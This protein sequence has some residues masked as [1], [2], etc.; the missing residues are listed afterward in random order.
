MRNTLEFTKC[1]LCYDAPCAKA[2]PS[3]RIDRFMRSVKMENYAGAAR[4]LP[5]TGNP[6]IDCQAPCCQVCPMKMDIPSLISYAYQSVHLVDISNRTNEV[7]L[8]C[9]LCGIPLENPFLLSSSVVASNYDMCARAFR[10]GWAGAAFK[11][12]SLM[13]MH[14][15]SP[16]FS[17]LRGDGV[18]F[19]GFKNIEQLS[20]HSLEENLTCFMELKRDF[21]TKVIIASIMGRNEEEWT[22]LAKAVTNAGADVVELNFSCP[23]MEDQDAGIT[24]GQDPDLV[25]R[26]TQA[27]CKGTD[28]PVLAKMTP[29]L[30]DMRLPARAAMEGGASGI[31]AINTIKSI[32]DVNLDTLIAQPEVHGKSSVGGYS[33]RAV[34]PIALR[35]ISDLRND[36]ALKDA[37]ISGMGGIYDWQDAVEFLLIGAGS[38]Q[39]TTAVM[40]YGYR[41]VEDLLDGLRNYMA[42]KHIFSI[43]ELIG[44]AS[45]TIVEADQMER[46]TILYPQFIRESCLGCGRCYLSCRDGGHQAIEFDTE[47]RLP[48][49]IG[50]RCVGC[51]LC[52]L[53]CP[54]N[55]I[56]P[57]YRRV[58]VE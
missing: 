34:K 54:A 47:T 9:E 7:S 36:P 26:Y 35:F 46:N 2:C 24:I 37:H 41:V 21:P 31:S 32:T 11:T 6:C 10:T 17:V 43:S 20:D 48:K 50:K 14:E 12:V 18:S 42:V 13:E 22:Y 15:T 55:S 57:A 30:E 1:L 28:R 38:L 45:T 25:R 23:N 5:K 40:E 3:M 16:R 39:V 58:T 29:N 27:A 44:K 33:G 51:H 56:K 4:L 19:A 8:A 49:L 53:V 52:V